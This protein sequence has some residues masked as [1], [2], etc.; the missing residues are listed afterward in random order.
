MTV[1]DVLTVVLRRWYLMV[2][3]ALL[4]LAG[5]YQATHVPPVYYTQYYVVVLAPQSSV[6]P[7]TFEDPAYGMAP[8]AGL[9]ASDYNKGKRQGLLGSA[10]T[11]LHGE[12]VREG[13][14]V[15]L[16]NDGS[17]WEPMYGRPNI[18]VQVVGPKPEE[19][20]AKAKQIGLDLV[21][22]LEKRQVE[23]GIVPTM[24]MTTVLSSSDPI[25]SQAGGSRSRAA[26][27]VT[28]AGALST[29]IFTIQFD[30]WRLWRRGLRGRRGR[31]ATAPRTRSPLGRP[32]AAQ[33]TAQRV[34]LDECRTP[35]TSS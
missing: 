26:L 19:V 27:A 6:F 35:T 13:S 22:L 17:Q 30:R 12:G 28:A 31:L 18:D 24:R 5:L 29:T 14:R 1:R 16:S 25:I 2:A 20:A 23:M 34:I 8:M 4:S 33:V 9:I 7:N 11:L 3:G 10:D 21:A 15:H 32:N